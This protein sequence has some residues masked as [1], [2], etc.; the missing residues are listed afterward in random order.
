MNA[1]K[2]LA[3][4]YIGCYNLKQYPILRFYI[5][6]YDLLPRI[7]PMINFYYFFTYLI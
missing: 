5:L 3:N 1:N 4:H 6:L 2:K 7:A